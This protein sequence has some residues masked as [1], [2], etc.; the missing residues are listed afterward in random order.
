MFR[1][2]R[3]QLGRNR[4]FHQLGVEYFNSKYSL[5]DD[6]ELILLSEKIVSRF[7]LQDFL[8]LKVNFIGDARDRE[9]YADHL[10]TW[11][12]GKEGA[13]SEEG[14]DMIRRNVMRLLDTKRQQDKEVLSRAG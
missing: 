8:E 9:V 7:A 14:R 6:L 13:L 11:L 2:E 3:P 5:Y 1:N 10:R 4:Q 12:Q